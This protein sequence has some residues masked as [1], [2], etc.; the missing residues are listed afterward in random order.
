MNLFIGREDKKDANPVIPLWSRGWASLSLT[1]TYRNNALNTVYL[2]FVFFTSAIMMEN[3]IITKMARLLTYLVL[4][5]SNM[6]RKPRFILY[7]HKTSSEI[8]I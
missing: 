8:F 6:A 7:F 5:S 4:S 2:K 1:G 3:G